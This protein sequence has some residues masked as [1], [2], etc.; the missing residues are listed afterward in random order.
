MSKLT[1]YEKIE[2]Y[3]FTDNAEIKGKR[4]ERNEIVMTPKE[5]EILN[6]ARA[7]FA[8]WCD[9]PS[10]TDNMVI[11]WLMDEFGIEKTTAY[12][13]LFGIKIL[14][15]NV[16][17]AKKSWYRHIIVQGCLE[18][19]EIARQNNDPKAMILGYDKIGKYTMCDQNENEEMPWNKILPPNFEPV[20]D[21]TVLDSNEN[22]FTPIDEEK[23]EKLRAKYKG[24]NI[25][26]AHIIEDDE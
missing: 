16:K 26:E 3:L 25:Q 7:G 4:K 18:S 20:P 11:D 24:L 9:T 15:G 23:R 17:N 5:M 1:T 14:L 22:K 6:R 2:K 12:N 19:I 21:I 10:L 13:D 8:H